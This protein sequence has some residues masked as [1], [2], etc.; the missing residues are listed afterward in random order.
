MVR[1][2]E[3]YIIVVKSNL[4]SLKC[5]FKS[6]PVPLSMFGWIKT[7]K[8]KHLS[9]KFGSKKIFCLKFTYKNRKKTNHKTSDVVQ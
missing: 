8:Y 7:A 3:S 4:D 9:N 5:Q 1:I 2:F 6:I